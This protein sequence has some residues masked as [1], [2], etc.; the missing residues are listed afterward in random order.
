MDK[1]KLILG[2]LG[3]IILFSIIYF[4]FLQEPQEIPL[5]EDS[6]FLKIKQI[7]ENNGYSFEK[8]YN[9][10][11][12]TNNVNSEKPKLQ[13]VKS[14]LDLLEFTGK[15][16]EKITNLKYYF[17]E[18]I[19]FKLTEVELIEKINEATENELAVCIYLEELTDVKLMF[20]SLEAKTLALNQFKEELILDS[21]I[22]NLNILKEIPEENLKNNSANFNKYLDYVFSSCVSFELE[23]NELEEIENEIQ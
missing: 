11:I 10:N 7:L 12:I 5:N 23:L 18:L 14:E 8:L 21:E 20:S 3:V 15:N 17:S 13:R 1:T 16:A 4:V 9:L 6:D 22:N 2:L 19:L